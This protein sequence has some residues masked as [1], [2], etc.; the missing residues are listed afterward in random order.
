MARLLRYKVFL[1]NTTRKLSLYFLQ[2]QTC[3]IKQIFNFI[4]HRYYITLDV[5]NPVLFTF[6]ERK[7]NSVQKL[8]CLPLILESRGGINFLFRHGE[9]AVIQIVVKAVLFKELFVSALFDNLSLV[10]NKDDI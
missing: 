9:L 3:S 1:F 10:H 8:I 2:I 4:S 5:K 7:Q 6:S